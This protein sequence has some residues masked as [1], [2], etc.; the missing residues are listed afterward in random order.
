M[1][2]VGHDYVM[3]QWPRAFAAIVARPYVVLAVCFSL[4][5]QRHDLDRR[6]N[7]AVSPTLLARCVPNKVGGTWPP[8]KLVGR[9]GVG[10]VSRLPTNRYQQYSTGRPRSPRLRHVRHAFA[11]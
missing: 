8:M 6:G 4:R 7:S 11:A 3:S 2:L 5:R 1:K 9:V 10:F